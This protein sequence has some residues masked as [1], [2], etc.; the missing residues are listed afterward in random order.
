MFE[1]VGGVFRNVS[2]QS[3]PVFQKLFPARGLAI[4]DYDNDGYLDALVCNNGEAPVLLHNEG[5]HQN[6]WVGVQLKATTSNPASV[7]AKITWSAGGVQRNRLKTGGGSYLA[8]HD[9]REILGIGK[10]T[11]M[12]SIEVHWPSG[13]V[14]LVENPPIDRYIEI[15]EGRGLTQTAKP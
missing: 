3:G 12:E 15:V 2:A 1:N 4:G 11:K 14:D 7:G 9:P 5:N 8:S 10:A 6:H 13:K